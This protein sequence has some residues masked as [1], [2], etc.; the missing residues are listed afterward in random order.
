MAIFHFWRSET[1]TFHKEKVPVCL[2]QDD[3]RAGKVSKVVKF[4]NASPNR[5]EWS[6]FQ[7]DPKGNLVSARNSEGKGVTLYY[8]GGGKFLQPVYRFEAT[9]QF[10]I[11]SAQIEI[12]R[13]RKKS[14]S[15]RAAFLES[16][17]R[18]CLWL[19]P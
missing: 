19:F 1:Y 9:R 14:K 10:L 18:F 3:L 13:N 11:G 2:N 6:Q 4:A 16:K 17:L 15:G 8:D 7:Y 5:K 12:E